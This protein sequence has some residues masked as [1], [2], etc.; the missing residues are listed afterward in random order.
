MSAPYVE[1]AGL[2]STIGPQNYLI[3][4]GGP[5][6]KIRSVIIWYPPIRSAYLAATLESRSVPE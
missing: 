3:A 1:I 4:V 5:F 2:K 6:E